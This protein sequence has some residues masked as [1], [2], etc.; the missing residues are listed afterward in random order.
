MSKAYKISRHC[1]DRVRAFHCDL[2]GFAQSFHS[3]H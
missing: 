1:F 2:G 3:R